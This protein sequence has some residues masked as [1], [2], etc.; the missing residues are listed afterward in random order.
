MTE[1]LGLISGIGHL[2]VD[3]AKAAKLQGYRVIAVAVVP[4]TDAELPAV[5]DKFYQIHIGKVGKILATLKDEGATQVTMIGKVT[6]ETLYK[7]GAIIPDLRTIKILASLP[8]RKDDT[9]MNALVRELEG[10][11]LTVMDQ[12][13]LIQPLL[14]EPGVLTQRRPTKEE[15]A[16][17]DFGFKMAKEIGRLDIG[18]TVVVKKMAVMAVEAIEGTDA[19]IKRGGLLGKG[20]VIV[21]KTSKPAQSRRFDMPSVGTTTL[22]TMIEAGATGLVVEAGKTLLVDREKTLAMADAH[23]ITIVAK[24]DEPIS[25]S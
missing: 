10:E 13:V 21:A 25:A 6:K 23:K 3:V 11:G 2:P 15:A 22:R 4:D 1:T 24:H 7:S 12:T 17:M 18:Q 9:I 20:G 16:D 19:C 14:P 8:D 5:V